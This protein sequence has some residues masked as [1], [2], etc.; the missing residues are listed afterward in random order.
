MES[1]RQSWFLP[2]VGWNYQ[3]DGI[4]RGANETTTMAFWSHQTASA[5]DS[6]GDGSWL[7]VVTWVSRCTLCS[8]EDSEYFRQNW[9]HKKQKTKENTQQ[10]ID[11][12]WKASQESHGLGLDKT[13]FHALL[14]SNLPAEEKKHWRLWQEGQVLIGAG[15]DTTA[16]ALTITHFHVLNNPE[17]YRSLKIELEMALPNKYDQFELRVVDQ[18]PYLVSYSK[19][20]DIKKTCLT[21]ITECSHQRRTEVSAL[22]TRRSSH[23]CNNLQIFLRSQHSSTTIPPNWSHEVSRLGNPSWC[24]SINHLFSMPNSKFDSHIFMMQ[25]RHQ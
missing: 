9:Q 22:L 11:G 12:N 16:N 10:V 13:I 6:Q 3:S 15:A 18:L 19:T 23:F 17:V 2:T 20:D 24:K 8:L 4:S 14:E 7:S 25:I 5:E 1:S 21:G